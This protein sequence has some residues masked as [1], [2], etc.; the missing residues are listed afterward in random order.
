[1]AEWTYSTSDVL[2]N[3][4][5]AKL[6]LSQF[7]QATWFLRMASKEDTS[8][9]N[10]LDDLNKHA[11]DA[12]TYGV[13][14]LLSGAG[15][16]DLATLTGNE[17]APTTY[18]DQL[19]VHELAHAILLVG[20]I[21]NQ[22]VL[23]DRRK[24]GRNRLA[25]WY[26]A[27]V[28]HGAA[29]QLAGYTPQT[30]TRYT[31]LQATT[32]ATRQILPGSLTDA[33][34]ITSGNTFMVDLLDKAVRNAK[35]LTTGIRPLKVAGRD[36][37]VAVLHPSQVTDMRTNTSTAQWFDIQKAAMTGG[38]IGDNPIFWNSIGMYHGVLLHENA[39]VTNSVTNAGAAFANSK[40]ALFCG[41][42]AATLAFG[43]GDGE[44][45]KFRWLEEL[46]DFGRQIGIGVSAIWGLKKVVFN[47]VDFGV[48]VIDT[49][50][51]DTD[52]L[53]AAATNAE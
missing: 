25:D 22:R 4:R 35:A 29:N 21:S 38:D 34:S 14:N 46:R 50:G 5:W 53:G 36:L 39:R 52:T 16:L 7:M 1:L 41:A 13:S 11:G 44:N 24:I 40:R 31:G 17:E 12:V 3:K 32:A 8:L 27:R 2:T 45:Q 10:V 9:I 33:A 15:V 51:T 48:I 6:M 20:P 30:D 37:Y 19:F 28:D 23:F 18:G 43:R 49:Y 47:S 42:Q 26:A